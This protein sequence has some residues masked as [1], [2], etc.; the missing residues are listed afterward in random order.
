MLSSTTSEGLFAPGEY[1]DFVDL[2]E[3]QSLRQLKRYHDYGKR[4]HDPQALV[5]LMELLGKVLLDRRVYS[6]EERALAFEILACESLRSQDF[7]QES[8][9]GQVVVIGGEINQV[10]L[11]RQMLG[12]DPLPFLQ[13]GCAQVFAQN[14]R[15]FWDWIEQIPGWGQQSDYL[16]L[17]HFLGLLDQDEPMAG[18]QAFKEPDVNVGIE[19]ARHAAEIDELRNDLEFA[20]DRANRAHQRLKKQERDLAELRRQIRQ[21]RENGEKLRVERSR[22]I[23]QDLNASQGQREFEELK[24]EHAKVI[25]RLQQT[26]QRLAAAQQQLSQNKSSAIDG[27]DLLRTID[28]SE[29]L[30]IGQSTPAEIGKI[31]RRFAVLLHPDRIRHLPPWIQEHFDQL[32]RIVNQA[33]DHC[34]EATKNKTDKE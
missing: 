8:V 4:V 12:K 32:L 28:P 34:L 22:R 19:A 23:R 26:A 10:Q 1:R 2:V 18:Q 25:H 33:C 15:K 7:G 27:L 20:E 5:G 3:K 31:R 6:L 13:A 14:Y 17:K 11:Y 21:E 30:D 24:Q 16:L 9:E 29:L